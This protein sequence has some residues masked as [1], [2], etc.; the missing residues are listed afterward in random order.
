MIVN[1][2]LDLN[3]SWEIFI[4]FRLMVVSTKVGGLPEV[5]PSEMIIFAKTEVDGK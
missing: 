5:L 1:E 2:P 3:G 4:I